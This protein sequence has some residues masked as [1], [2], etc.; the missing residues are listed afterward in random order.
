L[1]ISPISIALYGNLK[2]KTFS[3]RSLVLP[4]ILIAIGL[5]LVN[6]E[7]FESTSHINSMSEYI[8]GLS[9][10]FTA[11]LI[12]T[13]FAVYNAKILDKHPALA[14]GDWV[15]MLGF[16]TLIWVILIVTGLSFLPDSPLDFAKYSTVDPA[17]QRFLLGNAILGIFCSWLGSY[18]WNRA[19]T[20]LPVSIL[21]QLIIFETIFGLI[22][23]HLF[24]DEWPSGFSF[25]G[26]SMML[27]GIV[28]SLNVFRKQTSLIES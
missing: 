13:L 19:S 18:L 3:F 11:L 16:T 1:G 25:L 28:A 27:F 26:M 4:C 12:W 14:S 2:Q 23:V 6:L 20:L 24:K 9:F 22:F 8:L 15:T 17:F 7:A 21:G 10:G 5:A